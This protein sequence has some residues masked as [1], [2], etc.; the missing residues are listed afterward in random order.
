MIEA[1]SGKKFEE[2]VFDEWNELTSPEKEIYGIIAISYS[3]G[4]LLNREQI[5]IATNEASNEYQN[6][7]TNLINRHIL[8]E[9]ES[10]MIR[11]RHRVI[12][13][14]LMDELQKIQAPLIQ[15]LLAGLVFSCAIRISPK[16]RRSSREFRML[17]TFIN[18][19][20][21]YRILDY[22]GALTIYD[23]VYDILKPNY[24]FF[25]Q[26]GALE[27]KYGDIGRAENYLDQAY[28]LNSDDPFVISEYS[29]MLIKKAYVV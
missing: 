7:L 2:K 25:L 12:A 3:Q 8:R 18:H 10:G 27:L 20:Y 26:Y 13:E 22:H 9:L 19:E 14:K 5:L 4:H 24:Q 1:T 11:T 21:L 15:N 28:S 17:R 29:Y 6:S 23:G 16:V